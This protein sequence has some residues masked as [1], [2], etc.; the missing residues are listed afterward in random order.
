MMTLMNMVRGLENDL[1][2]QEMIKYWNHDPG[3]MKFVRASSNF[4]YTFEWKSKRFYL[5][6]THE[7]DNSAHHIQAELDFMMYLL[8]QGFDTV[9]PI[10]SLTG[11]WIETLI[12]EDGRYH[13]VV[14]AEAEGDYV[15]LDE[16]KAPHFEQWGESLARLHQLSETYAPS[17]P[18]RKSWVDSLQF[19]FSVLK[20]H[21][22]E[23]KALKEY[24]RIESWLTE[25]PFGVG[26]TGLIHYDYEL[27]NIFYMKE[28]SRFSAIDFD[29]SM[30]HWFAMDITSALGDLSESDDEESRMKMD[31]FISGYRSIKQLD[32]KYL[33]LMPEFRR[34]ADL[35]KFAKILRCLEHV[36]VS[37]MPEWAK[38]LKLRFESIGERL[39]SG[40]Q[41]H[42]SL[43]KIDE[44][45][46]YAVTQ[47]NVSEEQKAI[48]PVSAVYWLA[49]AAY[50]GM[51]P[52]ALYEDQ[53]LVG[54][55]VYAVDP[56]DGSYW[57]MAYM[58]DEKYQ[59]RGFGRTGMLA[60][61]HHLETEH[62]CEKIKI[63]HR[64]DNE[65]ASKMYSSLGFVEVDR[66]EQ[67]V[68]R[69]LIV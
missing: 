47:I 40:F 38:Q 62:H 23:H 21:P 46:W 5:R 1:A 59:G 27:D 39:R 34:F 53:E 58:I 49:E 32:D 42:I 22:W 12:T 13:G 68:I 57:I 6:F 18:Y 30:Y 41:A 24:E 8:D 50:C 11:N 69:E 31:A 56:E 36:D 55:S 64:I 63:G 15:T 44:N 48:F 51:T 4:V 20:R 66:D 16:M 54:L 29:D 60:L 35:Y 3:T 17:T 14:F 9:A 43:R 65:R 2:A 67:E 61:I 33:K 37:L 45:N 7:E 10:R 52:L 25:L 19:I 26:H 28:Q